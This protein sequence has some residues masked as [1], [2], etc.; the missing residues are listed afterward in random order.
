M[1]QKVVI[2]IDVK[3]AE[4]EKQIENLNQDL[5][6]TEEDLSGIEE[7]GDKM[8]GGLISGFKGMSKSVKSAI[9][10]LKTLRGALIATG[11]GAFALAIVSVTTALT[12]SEA[13]Q[14]RFAKWLNQITVVIGN[15]TDILGNFG[16]AI[17]SFVTGN[18]D[19][20][21]D[22]IAKVTEGIKNFGEETRKE[23][24]IAGELSDMR[25]KADKAERDLQ[26]QRAKADR[27]R[28]DLLEKAVNKEKFTVEERI[29]FLEEAGRIEEEI[30]N[31]EIAAAQLRL[32]ARQLENSL[33]ESTK[34]DLDEEARLKAELIQLETAKLTKQKEVTSQT[35]ALKAE[36]AAALKAIEDEQRREKEEQAKKDEQLVLDGIKKAKEAQKKKEEEDAQ[37]A[38][39]QEE[40]DARKLAMDI[41]IENRRTAAK[42]ASVDAAISLFGAE[43]AAGKAALIAKQV[44]AAQEMIQEARKTLTFSSLVAARSSAAVAE[45]TAQTAKIGFPQN[46]PMLIAYA[47][48]AVGIVQSISQAVGKSKSVASSIGGGG[49]AG[50]SIQTPQIPTASVPP[51]FNVVGTSGANQLAGAIAGQQQQPV[52]A[53]VV[54]NDVTT[55]QEL[56][57]NIVTGAT[58][59]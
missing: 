20:A 42:K 39:L 28:A 8:T 30:T 12:N 49:G 10:G 59:G 18:F 4:A 22:S 29:G 41:D 33:S 7:A 48:Q 52:K 16:N 15:V 54:S 35:I 43:T 56:D 2:D 55:A 44:M 1:A 46:I 37:A 58:I 50:A 38:K 11:I 36:E 19:E 3:S 47:L 57:R 14:N 32:E 23:I 24:A 45:G 13:G 51:S 34:E 9:T 40:R 25:A 17:L 6:Q 26:V 27:T 53:F 31:K 5:K 21:A